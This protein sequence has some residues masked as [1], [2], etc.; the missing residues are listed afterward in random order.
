MNEYNLYEREIEIRQR[1]RQLLE[2][3]VWPRVR[4]PGSW[5]FNP[6]RR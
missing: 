6:G 4:R 3:A 5:P 2:D 1:T